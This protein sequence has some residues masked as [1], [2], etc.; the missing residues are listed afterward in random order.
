MKL[1]K[2]DEQPENTEPQKKGRKGLIA[3]LLTVVSAGFAVLAKKKRDQVLDDSL[4]DEPRS[5]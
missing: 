1:R 2:H 4:W 3:L 5:L